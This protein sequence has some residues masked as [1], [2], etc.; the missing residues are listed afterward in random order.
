MFDSKM[1]IHRVGPKEK[2]WERH[3]IYFNEGWRIRS[4]R[5]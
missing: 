3:V 5:G 2:L 1:S 4:G